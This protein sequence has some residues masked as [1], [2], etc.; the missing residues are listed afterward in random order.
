VV[1]P[2]RALTQW[3][4]AHARS[5]GSARRSIAR[6]PSFASMEVFAEL[7]AVS[8]CGRP[9]QMELR[10]FEIAAIIEV[11]SVTKPYPLSARADQ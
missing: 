6:L 5:S 8:L 1:S 2:L 7:L 9:Q 4:F 10:L 11:A 3:L